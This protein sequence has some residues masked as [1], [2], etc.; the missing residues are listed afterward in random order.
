MSI[1]KDL[2]PTRQSLLGRLKN[3][4]DQESWKVFFDTYWKLIYNTAT[5]AG[6]SE[7]EAQ[8]VVQ[9]TVIS[10]LKSMPAFEYQAQKGSFKAWLLLLTSWRIGDHLRKRQSDAKG[11]QHLRNTSTDTPT[12][13]R[14][15]DQA[16]TWEQTWD[17]EWEHNLLEAA[18]E[19]VK[20]KADAL[21][22]QIYDL[23]FFKQWPVRRVALALN[24]NTAKVYMARH[25][26]G[27]LIKQEVRR[28]QTK[29]V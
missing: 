7:S 8:D 26:V 19:R 22:Y 29:V 5:R 10:V 15:P 6:L 13:E 16:L 4:N 1:V 18:I 20:L 23:C 9:E 12:V 24:V 28:L 25:R 27:N 17:E 14:V 11:I 21:Q 2:I 3:W